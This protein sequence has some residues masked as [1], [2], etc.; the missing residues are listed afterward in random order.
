MGKTDNWKFGGRVT[1]E[2]SDRLMLIRDFD[3]VIF[4]ILKEMVVAGYR[5]EPG[6]KSILQECRRAELKIVVSCETCDAFFNSPAGYRAQYYIA[7]TLGISENTSP[8][9]SLLPKLLDYAKTYPDQNMA[10][11]EVK[12]SLL[13]T[14]AKIWVQETNEDNLFGEKLTVDLI[15]DRWVNHAKTAWNGN[16]FNDQRYKAIRGVLAPV[17]TVL[18]I[19]GGWLTKDGEERI[20]PEEIRRADEISE[21]GFS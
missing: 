16:G 3:E 10:L 9:P 11:E 19:K 1:S 21:Y 15:V 17:E 6:N 13:L 18:E 2:R 20:D 7:P 12:K 4:A 5:V 8:I 14:Q